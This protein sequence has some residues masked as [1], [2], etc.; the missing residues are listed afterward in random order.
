VEVACTHTGLGFH[1]DVLAIVAQR[2]ARRAR[3]Q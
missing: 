1:S 3:A 2:L